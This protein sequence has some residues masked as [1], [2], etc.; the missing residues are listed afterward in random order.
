MEKV[1]WMTV[2]EER[3]NN[4]NGNPRVAVERMAEAEG[5]ASK[6][7]AKEAAKNAKKAAN[8]KPDPEGL[9]LIE[10]GEAALTAKDLAK[11]IELFSQAEAKCKA[12]SVEAVATA[13]VAHPRVAVL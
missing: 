7:A 11:A 2:S 10:E 12:S 8:K 1:R 3:C 13:R 4:N 6:S 9:K 5:G